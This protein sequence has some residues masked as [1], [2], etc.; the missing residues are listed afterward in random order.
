MPNAADSR[1]YKL[2]DVTLSVS[3]PTLVGRSRGYLW[4]PTLTRFGDG[5]LLATMSSLADVHN[6][7]AL[8]RYA[9]SGDD[10]RSWSPLTEPIMYGDVSV[11]TGPS[12]AI[13]LPYYLFPRGEK[14]MGASCLR[15]NAKTRRLYVVE[16]GVTITGM[17]RPDQSF[18]PRLGISGFVCNGQSTRLRDGSWLSTIYGCFA[19]ET[20]NTLVAI[21]S[22]DGLNW[23]FLSIIDDI[24]TP[25]P[26]EPGPCESAQC[27]LKD[28]RLMVVY[29]VGTALP[30]GQVFSSDE[31][32]T[33]SKPRAMLNA[34]SVQPSLATLEDG[35]LALSGGRWGA[36][37]W[38]DPSGRGER[39]SRV[40]LEEHHNLTNPEEAFE[41]P[42]QSSC[43][44]EV[45]PV[46]PRSFLCIY[47]RIPLSWNAIPE[48]S[49]LTNSVWVVRIDLV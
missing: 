13:I 7:P 23:R 33:W 6:N 30:Y 27:R 24:H 22:R 1:T 25:L 11:L 29:R 12:E 32:K 20:R 49:P 18:E 19:G 3:A 35:T 38:I 9:W 42:A 34:F 16:P 36:Y 39:F 2:R 44:T 41:L 47:D 26:G 40:N 46:G 37:L 5:T 31:G 14:A 48:G 8:A 45:V 28:G 10:G 43:Y 21:T 15:A 17:P 4:F